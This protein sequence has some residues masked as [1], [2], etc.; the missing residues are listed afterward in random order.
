MIDNS[1]ASLTQLAI[2]VFGEMAI[3]N[4]SSFSNKEIVEHLRRIDDDDPTNNEESSALDA[5]E[6]GIISNI[7]ELGYDSCDDSLTLPNG[8]SVFLD[9]TDGLH[10]SSWDSINGSQSRF[11]FLEQGNQVDGSVLTGF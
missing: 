3:R 6:S 8:S 7:M 11:S 10:G 5:V 2:E 9:E 4:P 1:L